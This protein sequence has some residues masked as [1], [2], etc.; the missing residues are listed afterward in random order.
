MLKIT[1][2]LLA[3]RCIRELSELSA[4]YMTDAPERINAAF[5]IGRKKKKLDVAKTKSNTVRYLNK[6]AVVCTCYTNKTGLY[7]RAV[8]A[9][10]K[11]LVIV[12]CF[13]PF[14]TGCIQPIF[15]T[16]VVLT[17]IKISKHALARWLERNTSQDYNAG[18]K[19]LGAAL[20]EEDNKLCILAKKDKKIAVG[21]H[22]RQIQCSD[23]GIAIVAISNPEE[24]YY[25]RMDWTLIT[26]LDNSLLKSWNDEAVNSDYTNLQDRIGDKF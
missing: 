11:Q 1:S 5:T 12:S 21:A 25:P 15:I 17:K 7:T 14:I 2:E 9:I 16:D 19:V 18:L 20:L 10:D 3:K 24:E 23:G 26:Y 4:Q 6:F 22:E 13:M 8:T